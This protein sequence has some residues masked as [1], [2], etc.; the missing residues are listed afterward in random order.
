MI[1]TN[2]QITTQTWLLNLQST[3]P[4]TN[5]KQTLLQVQQKN[6]IHHFFHYFM[7]TKK[8]VQSNFIK[9]HRTN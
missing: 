3:F 4:E 1:R 6:S 8:T 9:L 7:H 2:V 5:Y